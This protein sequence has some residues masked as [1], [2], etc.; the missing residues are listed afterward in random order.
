MKNWFGIRRNDGREWE[1]KLAKKRIST[2]FGCVE[3]PNK[4]SNSY[5]H[6]MHYFFQKE[7]FP[8]IYY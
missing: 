5:Y 1:K 2:T 3:I 4:S 7:N 6:V 8:G